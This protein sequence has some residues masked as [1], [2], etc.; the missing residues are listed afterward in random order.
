MYSEKAVYSFSHDVHELTSLVFIFQGLKQQEEAQ[1]FQRSFP[2][3]NME[4]KVS[5]GTRFWCTKQSGGIE[6]D[7]AGYPIQLF[8]Q[9]T[10]T[11]SCVCVEKENF[12]LP[13]FRKY[14]KCEDKIRSCFIPSD[15]LSSD[16]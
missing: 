16:D 3:C 4:Y 9:D 14:E 10:K 2:P 8:N 12:E 7:W 11:F 6:R 13:Q 15:E 1:N 5:K